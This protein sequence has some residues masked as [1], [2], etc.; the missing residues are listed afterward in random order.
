MQDLLPNLRHL[1]AFSEA[2]RQGSVSRAAEVVCLSQSA[3]TQAI[4]KLEQAIG[5]DLFE[6]AGLGVLPTAAGKAYANRVR[7][8]LATLEAGVAE[9]VRIAGGRAARP[10]SD[11]LPRLTSTQLK[12]LVAVGS[13][14]NF[15]LAARQIGSSQ[16]AVHRSARELEA[17]TGVRLFEKSSRGVGLSRA[18]Q[19]LWQAC[20]LAFAELDQGLAD[21]AQCTGAGSGR[22][23]IGCMPLA[24]HIVMPET[25]NAFCAQRPAVDIH[26][27]E[28]PYPDLL[29]GLRH[30]EIDVLVGAL[31]NP[32]PVD[33]IAQEPLFTASL[34]IAARRGHPLAT[35]RRIT[36]D[37]LAG[38]PW[39]LP[40]ES[41]PT[42]AR[43]EHLMAAHPQVKQRGLIE[44]SS[45]VLIRGILKDS[46]RLTLISTH[47]VQFEV[48][49]G[50]LAILHFKVEDSLRE[51]GLTFR[52]NWQATQIQREFLDQLRRVSTSYSE[53]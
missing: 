32:P 29:H 46:D 26:L 23:V 11:V 44:S 41:T 15:T 52:R 3:V 6:R 51:I 17:V 49:L 27:I 36:L 48:D 42:R 20:K 47:Q 53:N 31:R 37:E 40:P 34:C 19:A 14:H 12:V 13:T 50:L 24:R 5:T 39:I 4:A 9:A 10:G 8:A 2:E 43:F 28:A 33:D 16:P 25:I 38:F 30:G 22:I 1:R 7:R 45:Q 21:V 35:K 18:G